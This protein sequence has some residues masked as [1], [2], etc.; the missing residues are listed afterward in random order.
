MREVLKSLRLV[1]LGEGDFD[2]TDSVFH[3]GFSCVVNQ[4]KSP[5]F[6]R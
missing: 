3:D 6:A 4:V 2:P 1:E 5:H